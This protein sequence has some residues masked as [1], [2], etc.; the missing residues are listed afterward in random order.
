LLNSPNFSPVSPVSRPLFLVA[1]EQSEIS[2]PTNACMKA[3]SCQHWLLAAACF[4]FVD[5]S[6]QP[7]SQRRAPI[8]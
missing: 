2:H 8:N 4:S 1:L 6:F 3:L 5:V 7:G